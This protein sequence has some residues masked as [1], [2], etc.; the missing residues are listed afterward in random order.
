VLAHNRDDHAKQFSFCMTKS[1]VWQLAP[2]YDLTYSQGPG[3][4]HSTSVLGHGKDISRTELRALSQ[5]ADLNQ[6]QAD[7]I[8]NATA[9]I[10]SQWPTY[11]KARSVSNESTNVVSDAI[12][13]GLKN[14]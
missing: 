8:I 1:G 14:L 12:E 3:G 10:V 7:N 13:T 9:D 5:K 2:A 6:E 4:E 11:A